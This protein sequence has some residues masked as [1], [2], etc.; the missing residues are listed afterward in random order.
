M[1]ITRCFWKKV[2]KEQNLLHKRT[3]WIFSILPFLSIKILDIFWTENSN[4][5]L[6]HNEQFYSFFITSFVSLRSSV[7]ISKET[8][9]EK[10]SLNWTI[11]WVLR[12]SEQKDW[13]ETIF[14]IALNYIINN[15]IVICISPLSYFSRYWCFINEKHYLTVFSFLCSMMFEVN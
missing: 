6:I 15:W 8:N 5:W 9:S 4:H 3:F 7:I 10:T 11:F 2:F 1:G 13:A 14:S 12:L